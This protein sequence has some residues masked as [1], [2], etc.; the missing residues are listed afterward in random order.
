MADAW[1][2]GVTPGALE[3]TNRDL[4]GRWEKREITPP[5]PQRAVAAFPPPRPPRR[6][7]GRVRGPPSP[8]RLFAGGALVLRPALPRLQEC[9]LGL[10]RRGLARA[11][12]S[13]G[14][15]LVAGALRVVRKL[16]PR[17]RSADCLHDVARQ[18]AGRERPLRHRL[19]RRSGPRASRGLHGR[20]GGLPGRRGDRE[21]GA[22]PGS[23]RGRGHPGP[24]HAAH[25]LWVALP[26]HRGGPPRPRIPRRCARRPAVGGIPGPECRDGRE[27]P[28]ALGMARRG[29]CPDPTGPLRAGEL[30]PRCRRGLLPEADGVPPD[31]RRS[32]RLLPGRRA[33]APR[34]PPAP[35]A[36]R[37]FG[38]R[39]RPSALLDVSGA[40]SRTGRG[41]GDASRTRI[42]VSR[43]ARTGAGRPL[44]GP[45]DSGVP[46]GRIPAVRARLH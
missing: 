6:L 44:C 40:N 30:R 38:G 8:S 45:R 42:A 1:P 39:R 29:A 18:L 4:E 26:R 23:L 28:F 43:P 33:S 35:P 11:H 21:G 34:P 36:L 10:P 15:R 13:P 41:R 46:P 9:A 31:P 17:I 7:G 20:G 12:R 19:S 2:D 24:V 3:A 16:C 32:H 25:L 22:G 14:L 5:R 37:A 27:A